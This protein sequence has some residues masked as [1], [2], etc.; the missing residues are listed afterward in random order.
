MR[1][2]HDDIASI[3]LATFAVARERCLHESLTQRSILQGAEPWLAAGVLKLDDEL[4][5][6]LF[7]VRGIDHALHL[8]VREAGKF[9]FLIDDHRR[10]VSLLQNIL[11]EIRLQFRQ[12]GVDLFELL[13]LRIGQLGSRAHEILVITFEQISRFRIEPELVALLI[14]RLD[15]RE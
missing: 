15:S 10:R 6:L 12:L 1:R 11:L 9:F 14:K 8:I 7:G 2:S 4:A 3:E 13:L 5:F